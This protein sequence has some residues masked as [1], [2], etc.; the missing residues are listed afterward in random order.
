MSL[1]PIIHQ[2]Q[3][4]N[5][6]QP[7]EDQLMNKDATDTN[8]HTLD[9]NK[10][11]PTMLKLIS[12]TLVGGANYS[13]IYDN[14]MNSPIQSHNNTTN[15]NQL[16]VPTLPEIARKVAKLEKTQLD[17]KQY[18]AYEIIACTFL[19][20][21][22]KDGNNPKTTLYSSLQQ[23][24]GCPNTTDMEDLVNRLKARGGQDQLLMFLTGPAGSSKSTAVMVAKQFCFE[25]CIAVG[26]MWSDK[27]FLFTAYTV[28]AASLF[29]G[30]TISKAA[31][32]NQRRPLS[33]E[34]KNE[35]QDV[36]ILIIDEISF[37]SD[38]IF[39]M[40]DKKL[41][42][43]GNRNQPFGGI[44]I[45]FAGDFRL[46]EPVGSNDKE[47][48]FSSKSSG[49]WDNCINAIIILDNDHCFKEDPLY[50]QMLKRMWN[51]ELSIE[52]RYRINT[53]VIGY[54]GLTI[55]ENSKVSFEQNISILN[56]LLLKV[57]IELERRWMLCMSNKQGT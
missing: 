47:L 23:S 41:K 3:L 33:L 14:E 49:H 43:I 31:F 17:E 7:Q 40:L 53:R 16:K 37:M 2:E 55:P 20:G 4:T 21:L 30:V 57:F 50:G 46:L 26:A 45:I 13:D 28:S 36:Q 32:I 18:I 9:T 52:D 34:D 8:P 19:L 22:V 44:S 56:N 42:D 35:W 10:T 12:G 24:M 48:L 11:F 51:G 27:T 39:R 38:S 15:N 1:T 54:K 6:P 25:F 5:I 29:G